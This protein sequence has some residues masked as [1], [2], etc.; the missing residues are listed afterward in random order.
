MI[1]YNTFLRAVHMIALKKPDPTNNKGFSGKRPHISFKENPKNYRGLNDKNWG[2]GFETTYIEAF[3]RFFCVLDIDDYKDSDYNI[4]GAVPDEILTTHK[5]KTQREGLHLYLLSET[6]LQIQQNTTVPLDL[7]AIREDSYNN[8]KY[9]GLVVGNYCYK[10]KYEELE[11]VYYIKKFYKHND[12]PLLE[13]DINNIVER[14]YENLGLESVE[15]KE[16]NPI[17][18]QYTKKVGNKK[19]IRI[20]EV[21][22]PYFEEHLNSKHMTAFKLN[23]WLRKI[24]DNER[25]ILANWF[26]EDFGYCMKDINNFRNEF[27]KRK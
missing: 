21:L 9:G 6:P 12:Q 14:I 7:K 13:V 5:S 10:Q 20:Y 22:K 1:D 16:Y 24:D 4:L 27:T 11:G 25:E 23:C 18:N 19:L 3:N 15:L 2:T 17:K 26:I 8:G